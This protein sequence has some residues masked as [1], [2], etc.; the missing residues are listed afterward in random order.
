MVKV[1]KAGPIR[2]SPLAFICSLEL[3]ARDVV[4]GQVVH[5]RLDELK[6]LLLNHTSRLSVHHCTQLLDHLATDT[7][8]LL[9]GLVE[10]VPN[11]LLHIIKGLDTLSQP[12]T[13]VSEPLMVKS[14][15]PV[16]A[17]E[18]DGVGNDV[19][20]IPLS[21]LVEIVLVKTHEAPKTL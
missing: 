16:L 7:L 12:Q 1:D 4:H 13:E 18:L 3:L 10:G 19:V 9:R 2:L 11:D 5:V 20:F 6:R 17:Q 14:N 21:Q 15:R 8:P